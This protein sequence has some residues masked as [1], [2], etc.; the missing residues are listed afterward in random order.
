MIGRRGTGH[1]E[2]STCAFHRV[3]QHMGESQSATRTKDRNPALVWAREAGHRPLAKSARRVDALLRLSS[4]AI[5]RRHVN[6][7]KAVQDLASLPLTSAIDD[8]TVD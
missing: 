2:V 1:P 5:E 6:R 4:K 8:K 3:W 7:S